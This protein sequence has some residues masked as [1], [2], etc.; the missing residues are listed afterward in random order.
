LP[1]SPA[2]PDEIVEAT[3]VVSNPESVNAALPRGDRRCSR[4]CGAP[5]SISKDIGDQ[6][7]PHC[8]IVSSRE[9]RHMLTAARTL[10]L[11]Q[12]DFGQRT[13][14]ALRMF[15]HTGLKHF[16]P[17]IFVLPWM[18]LGIAYLVES[19]LHRRPGADASGRFHRK[20][21]GARDTTVRGALAGLRKHEKG[22]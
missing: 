18:F 10:L 3:A 16:W 17:A 22:T 7:S 20:T 12:V 1:H 13:N 4:P 11:G 2:M 19:V 9:M 21:V 15:V 6:V 5:A 8:P 14:E